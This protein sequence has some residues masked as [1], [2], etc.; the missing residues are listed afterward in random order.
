MRWGIQLDKDVLSVKARE[1]E[2]ELIYFGGRSVKYDRAQSDW[3][4]E[5]RMIQ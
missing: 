5:C 2:Q 4:R 3:S 1:L